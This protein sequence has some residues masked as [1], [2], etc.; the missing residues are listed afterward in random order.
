MRTD[1]RDREARAVATEI[2]GGEALAGLLAAV[3]EAERATARA[4]RLAGQL[5]GSGTAEARHGLPLDLL[6]AADLGLT[7][8]DRHMLITAGQVLETMPALSAAHRDG[9]VSWGQVRHVVAAVRRRS[10]E[11][12]AVVDA[13]I[14][15]TL[16][17]RDRTLDPDRLCEAV[18]AAVDELM[19]RRAVEQRDERA[20]T[21][22]RLW[23]QL[24]LDGRVA[25]GFSYDTLSASVLLNALA[26]CQGRPAADDPDRAPQIP[27]AQQQ[28]AAASLV[29]ICQH[30]LAGG[31]GGSAAGGGAGA[32]GVDQGGEARGGGGGL[33]RRARPAYVVDIKGECLGASQ[34]GRLRLRLP[35]P[36]PRV[37]G[38]RVAADA[39]AGA[40]VRVVV[41]AGGAPMAVTGVVRTDAANL[42][43]EVGLAKAREL[44]VPR[45]QLQGF[46]ALL[47]AATLALGGD[48][49][50]ARVLAGQRPL[51]DPDQLHAADIPTATRVAVAARDGGCR[52]YGCSALVD[53][54][55]LHHLVHRE[56]GGDHHPDRLALFCR[57]DHR[58]IHKHHWTLGL[59]P[60]TGIIT[61]RRG[62]RVWRTEPRG[63]P[64]APAPPARFRPP[65][66][67]CP[68]TDP[69]G[70]PDPPGGTDLPF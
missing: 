69:P 62:D 23:A 41:T 28:S 24:R 70:G 26:A 7:G 43:L 56:D 55:D 33:V 18:D 59:D 21:A 27:T 51:C 17:D 31:G 65:T 64:L 16:A 63:S 14:A 30:W 44:G 45:A 13:R 22:N 68:G 11:D 12:R 5:A 53:W 61:G 54:C 4:V 8:G 42:P 36:A 47:A 49:Q 57:G 2:G 3:H 1:V 6:L 37:S 25:G 20:T 38:K 32:G 50:V 34:P 35:G 29:D 46:S 39:A 19:S 40:D 10:L 48:G 52:F 67:S 15:D 58:R 60:A 9:R 66:E